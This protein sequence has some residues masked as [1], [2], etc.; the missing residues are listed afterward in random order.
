MAMM[1]ILQNYL[2]LL[3]ATL[4][5]SYAINTPDI[6]LDENIFL[7]GDFNAISLY[8]SADKFNLS[9]SSNSTSLKFYELSQSNNTINL[10]DIDTSN[11][12]DSPT[13]W[14]LLDQES[15][16]MIINNEPYIFNLSSG[17]SST[18]QLLDGWDGVDGTIK[19][20]YYDS[21]DNIIYLGGSLSYNDTYGVVQ[22]NCE[23]NQL[24][25]VPFG[26]FGEDS[27]VNSITAYENS[28]SDIDSII[29]G[30]SFYTIGYPD[31]LNITY[32]STEKNYTI[33]RNSSTV[34]DISQKI[35]I[36]AADVSAT[37]GDNYQSIICPTTDSS[38]GWILP[39]GSTG[40]WSAI[41]Q[42]DAIPA[43]IRL[44]NSNSD[45]NY[46]QYFR[47][48][49]YPANG[50]MNLT[51][52][53]PSD[54][55]IKY[56]DAYCP[57][58]SASTLQS[59]L[60]SANVSN[61]DYY[62]FINN[63][64][65]IL[66]LTDTFQDFGFVN[67]IDV[68]S[69]TVQVLEYSGTYAE[70]LGIEL[71]NQGI[72]IYAN[73]ALNQGDSCSTSDDYDIDVYSE[74]IGDLDWT[75]S[76][77][78]SYLLTN[79]SNSD[80]SSDEGVRFNVF[81]PVSGEYNVLMYTAGCLEDGSCD[82]RGIV[83]VTLY[84]A[85]GNSLASK[86]IYQT[87]DY[88]KYDSIYTGTLELQSDV[89]PV[90][91]EMKLYSSANGNE[92]SYTTF[93]AE[94]VKLNYIQL[95]LGDVTGNITTNVTVEKSG[96]LELN[97]IFEYSP[98][99]FTDSDIDYPIGNTTV[100][101]L[102]STILDSNATINSMITNDSSLIIAGDFSS[103]YGDGLLSADLDVDSDYENQIYISGV[104]SIVGGL[105]GGYISTVY[106]FPDDLLMIGSFDGFN[107][108]TTTSNIEGSVIY[109]SSNDSISSF[110]ITDSDSIDNI[111]G[112]IFNDTEYLLVTYNDTSIDPAVVNYA[113]DKL[114]ANSSTL[115]MYIVSSLDSQDKD[116][117]VDEELDAS[118]VLGS[119]IMYDLASNNIVGVDENNLRSV[120][121]S[122]SSNFVSGVYIGDDKIAVGGSNIYVITN[123]SN[124]LLSEDFDFND[125][126]II[127]S[128]MWYK[129][130]LIFALNGTSTFH[131]DSINGVGFYNESSDNVITLNESFTGTISDMAVDPEF[132]TIIA[133]GDFS[134]GDCDSI[135]TFSNDSETV[136]V[137]RSLSDV[138]GT[139]SVINYYNSY[140][141]LVGG[142]FTTDNNDT[143]LGIYDTSNNTLTS[144]DEFSS[145]LS[146][147]I[148][149]FVFGEERK[150]NK[151]LDDVIVVMGSNYIGYFNN[152]N[153]NSLHDGL[154][155][156]D[157]E[158]ADIALLNISDS[159]SAT[160]YNSQVL[161]LTGRFEVENYGTVSSAI[162][163]GDSW[164]PY[165]LAANDLDAQNAIAQKVVR[166]TSMFLYEG[167]F[168][169][170]SAS[171]SSTSSSSS[172]ATA[173]ATS[174][175]SNVNKSVQDFTN[176]Q[177]TGIGFALALGTMLL[178]G[179]VGL[180]YHILSKGDE[181]KIEGLKL[182]GEDRVMHADKLQD[183]A[184]DVVN[185]GQ[186][187]PIV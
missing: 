74:T 171:S 9:A 110:N 75:I 25:S 124:S 13:L 119:I 36:S 182:T 87:N 70:L 81:L 59:S 116:W 117:G 52:V 160:F 163:N 118:Y 111:A 40:S 60:E 175:N 161:I 88:E 143:Y 69:F 42:S 115:G 67:S 93:V 83:N 72:N 14:Q 55:Q 169:L 6:S 98:Y 137:N 47:V 141:V 17:S 66:Q 27:V 90:T 157:P 146:G 103:I 125:N 68:S 99:N 53:D 57:L 187:T 145:Q 71:Y 10:L 18:P 28:D 80:I 159:S 151:T 167:S 104:D 164:I 43:K 1:S 179:G 172:S 97:G 22:Y 58:S 149:K 180:G 12:S 114:F 24:L 121:I 100:N 5:Q 54:F 162:W 153:W 23:S 65:T 61:N 32:N 73:N 44:Y 15:T 64:Q 35:P 107:N 62:T 142:D 135:C 84:D 82:H 185:M 127:S 19:S 134:V 3:L 136:T 170:T 33:I 129:S 30:G 155:L 166:K 147:P 96:V 20:I 105:D 177:V 139:I 46:V 148:K 184:T 86:I 79:V 4:Y 2:I 7:L 126:T 123:E 29:F 131:G 21:S 39:D 34:I 26:G 91:L 8:N 77:D 38:S 128:L 152:S 106:G 138:S 102:G 85:L 186:S 112:I 89:L 113:N 178:L 78:S 140:H 49:T 183:V 76:S 144:L 108:L 154:N 132:G 109:Y 56:C 120:N 101:L 37:S 130:N 92:D 133:V 95:D 45:S 158:F 173:T 174:T 63:N 176:G 150:N 94:S 51:Y 156:D 41:L 122:Q 48:Q 31:L 165:T 168:T 181:E 16:I 50:I 11:L